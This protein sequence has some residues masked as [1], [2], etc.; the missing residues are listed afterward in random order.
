MGRYRFILWRP[1]Q[2]VPV[3][4][5]VSLIS[6]LLVHSIPGDPVRVLLGTRATASVIEATRAQYGLDQPLALQY[7]YFLKN[8][9]AGEFGKSIIFKVGIPKL[10]VGR[11]VPTLFLLGYAILLSVVI[12]IG[13]A[14]LAALYR[15][16]LPDQ[17]VRVYSTAGLGLP[18]F[19]LG[20]VLIILF[21]IELGLFPVS[22]YGETPLEHLHHLFLPSLT[23][24]L[25]LSPVLIRNLRASLLVEMEA[26][27]VK[28]ARSRGIAEARIF[29]RHVF[30]NSLIPTITLLGV[31]IGW[32]I[33]GTV[34]V[35]Q[36][37]SVPGLG[38]LMVSS[39]FARDYLVV[40]VVTLAFALAVILTNFIVDIVTVALDPRIK[41]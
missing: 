19:W 20:I 30:R 10:V 34:V 40:Q 15:G 39:I 21:S 17:L 12:A 16:R 38:S 35:E 14:V 4:L 41:L 5:G 31:N 22:G 8:L 25:A 37:F 28:A 9:A 32:L 2:L 13:L 1:L 24:A 11:I 6:F 3:L 27:Y 26:D 23:I 7:L 36:V 33:G 18:A 29:R